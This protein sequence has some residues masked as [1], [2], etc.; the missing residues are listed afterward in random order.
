MRKPNRTSK[1]MPKGSRPAF[2]LVEFMLAIAIT[3]MV[4]AA[5]AA[6]LSAVALSTEWERGRRESVI[7]AQAINVRLSSYVTP[8]LY[9]LDSQSDNFVIWLHDDRES[10]TVHATEVRWIDLDSQTGTIQV[11]RVKFPGSWSQIQKDQSDLELPKASD[12]W[13]VLATYKGLTYTTEIR[14]CDRVDQFATDRNISTIEGSRLITFTIT[15]AEEFGGQT[16][17][18]AASIR[19]YQEPTL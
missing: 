7:R 6:M 5:S 16:L 3:G 17:V 14:L 19:Q 8:S 13:A 2:T 11:W 9:I 4:A 12:W 15:F 1:L 18:S 10:G